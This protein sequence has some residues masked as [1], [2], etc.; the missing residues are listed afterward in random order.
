MSTFIKWKANKEELNI[1]I[2]NFNPILV[3]LQETFLKPDKMA[4]L[5]K[6]SLYYLPGEESTGNSHGGVAILVN[7]AIRSTQ[8]H[9]T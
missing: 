4:T 7:N 3:S 6:C 1:L 5:I 9:P 2:S 8:S